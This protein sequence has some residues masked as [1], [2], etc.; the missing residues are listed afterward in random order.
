MY[1]FLLFR[2]TPSKKRLF[3]KRGREMSATYDSQ[4]RTQQTKDYHP[5][6]PSTEGTMVR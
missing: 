3:T 1:Y 4:F 5:L 2:I 6:Q